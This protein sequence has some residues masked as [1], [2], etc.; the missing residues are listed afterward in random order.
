MVWQVIEHNQV[1]PLLENTLKRGRLPNAYLFVGPAHVGKMT[2]A[3]DLARA[4]NCESAEKPCGECT[5]CRKI[6]AGKHADIQVIGLASGN[7]KEVRVKEISI[8]QVREMQHSANLPPYEGRYKVFI[9]D[10]AEL[11]SIEAANCLLKTLE[12]P[13]EKVIFMLLAVNDNLLPATVNSRCQ[14]LELKPLPAAAVEENLLAMPGMEPD[15]AKLLSR[16]SHGCVGWAKAAAEDDFIVE[17]HDEKIEKISE[18]I[19]A[20][21]DTR[22]EYAAQLAAQ[23]SQNRQT[24]YDELN[25][26]VD[27]WHDILLV[28]VGVTDSVTGIN[29]M[30]QLKDLS[31]KY[32][33]RQIRI[34]ISRIQEALIQLNCNASPRLVLDVL[35]LNIPG[36]N[37]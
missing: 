3:L 10:G 23:F 17:E 18:V 13:A 19:N 1:V 28:K 33:I 21:I 24:V 22:F 27:W 4:L 5:A 7:G 37:K 20:G 11:L 30:A 36:R 34:F 12:E 25:Q 31:A 32:D 9:I 26:W 8:D 29:M 2:L 16:L 15:R 35:M 6:A 14:R